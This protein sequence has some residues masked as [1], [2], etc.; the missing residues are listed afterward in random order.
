MFVSSSVP[1]STVF[2]L[3]LIWTPTLLMILFS[4]LINRY[5]GSKPGMSQT[6]MDYVNRMF[7]Y[8]LNGFGIV[9]AVA[10]TLIGLG[11]ETAETVA[12]LLG[13]AYFQQL[14]HVGLLLLANILIQFMIVRKPSNLGSE[15][16]EKVV[17]AVVT[18]AIPGFTML[19][20]LGKP[21]F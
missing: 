11:V 14:E 12:G 7:F 4:N 18:F 8:H 10:A 1:S 3:P 6:V 5:L 13:W 17:V 16:F 9:M 19:M 15:T 20:A 21:Y 2:I